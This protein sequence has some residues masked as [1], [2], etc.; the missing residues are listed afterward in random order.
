MLRPVATN[1]TL[2]ELLDEQRAALDRARVMPS[3]SYLT[4][5][6]PVV[7]RAASADLTDEKAVRNPPRRLTRSIGGN[8]RLHDVAAEL[9]DIAEERAGRLDPAR[10]SEDE[11]GAVERLLEKLER[12]D[13]ELFARFR[14]KAPAPAAA[15]VPAAAPSRAETDETIAMEQST[16]SV[17]SPEASAPAPLQLA[18]R[19]S[20]VVGRT[21]STIVSPTNASASATSQPATKQPM[22]FR[23]S[24]QIKKLQAVSHTPEIYRSM[25]QSRDAMLALFN[26]ATQCSEARLGSDDVL[27]VME[28]G[29]RTTTSAELATIYSRGSDGW[30]RG[31]GHEFLMDTMTQSAVFA[32][33][34]DLD[35]VA[36]QGAIHREQDRIVVPIKA[37]GVVIAAAEIMAASATV[38]DQLLENMARVAGMFIRNNN[39]FLE[40]KWQRRKAEAMLVMARQLSEETLEE[41]RLAR[42]IMN[43]TTQLIEADTCCL[44]LVGEDGAIARVFTESTAG[45]DRT[46]LVQAGRSIAELVVDNPAIINIDDAHGDSR[47]DKSTDQVRGKRTGSVL[48]VPVFFEG[49]IVAVQQLLRDHVGDEID[50]SFSGRDIELMKTFT[51]FVGV[52]LRNCR[53]NAELLR[54]QRKSEAILAVVRD[55][56]NTDIRDVQSVVAQILSGARRLLKADRATLFLVDKERNDLF[57]DKEFNTEGVTIRVKKGSGIVG[58]VAKTGKAVNV[59]DAYRDARFNQEIDKQFG[60]RTVSI[61]AEPI[62]GPT[63]EIIAVAQLINK[64]DRGLPDLSRS[65]RTSLARNISASQIANGPGGANTSNTSSVV[66]IGGGP[67]QSPTPSRESPP[68]SFRFPQSPDLSIEAPPVHHPDMSVSNNDTTTVVGGGSVREADPSEAP[69]PE[70]T[71]GKHFIPFNSDDHNAF[72]QFALFAGMALSNARLLEFAVK[73]AEDA[74]K[75]SQKGGELRSGTADR[76]GVSMTRSGRR[77]STLREVRADTVENELQA[78]LQTTLTDEEV[79][80]AK[81]PDFNLFRFRREHGDAAPDKCARIVCQLIWETGLP[82]QF[83]CDM[84]TLMRFVLACRSRYRHVP[85]HNWFHAVDVCQTVHHFLYTGNCADVLE[86]LEC[87]VLLVVALVH[88]LDHMGLNNSYHFKTESPLGI[89][90]SASGN[91]SVLEVHHCNLAIEILDDKKNDVFAGLSATLRAQAIRSLIDCVLATDMAKHGDLVEAIDKTLGDSSFDKGNDAHR[92]LAMLHITKAADISNVTKPFDVSRLWGASVTEE[93]YRQGDMEKEKGVDVLP[94][95]D[96]SL[97]TELAKGQLGFINFMARKYFLAVT[98]TLFPQLQYTVDG[99]EANANRWQEE[100]DLADIAHMSS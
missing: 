31:V 63:G 60:Y 99:I 86:P 14:P 45:G 27:K 13:G 62:F 29:F 44:F 37:D 73:A 47:F 69:R 90:S 4:R 70:T 10:L 98:R 8:S 49:R 11:R 35:V 22:S 16:N 20:E 57:S 88:D 81:L 84:S 54:E 24:K 1:T 33:P 76:L 12:M 80:S 100:L 6:E 53:V 58:E 2:R 94:M 21:E 41:E 79:T 15:P 5:I 61:I 51:T 48:S 46:A 91:T 30:E 40:S 64:V 83:G 56:N 55:M 59:P 93:F 25:V 7:P 78:L 34:G 50:M 32:V 85:Y 52:C 19:D 67:T 95:N 36:K 3:S 28:A 92:R 97:R 9:A 18:R 42:G 38:E 96:R 26:F 39:S 77:H 74:V 66:G 82:V 71:N 87:F 17:G 23:F 65:F 68:P 43:F 72:K 75:L 89:L